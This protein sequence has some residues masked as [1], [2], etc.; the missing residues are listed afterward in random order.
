MDAQPS[1]SISLVVHT[2]WDS[3]EF[4]LIQ[5]KNYLGTAICCFY[6]YFLNMIILLSRKTTTRDKLSLVLPS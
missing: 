6:Y 4:A 3:L 5:Q 1:S 2:A